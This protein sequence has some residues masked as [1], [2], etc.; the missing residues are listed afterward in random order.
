MNA[1]AAPMPLSKAA[2]RFLARHRAHCAYFIATHPKHSAN[3]RYCSC[4]RVDL[5]VELETLRSENEALR[6]EIVRLQARQMEMF[7]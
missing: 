7:T 5:E 3:V 2:A 1:P 6:A 4:G